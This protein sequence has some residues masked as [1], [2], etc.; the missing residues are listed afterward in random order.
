MDTL[1]STDYYKA[2]KTSNPAN[3]PGADFPMGKSA[4]TIPDGPEPPKQELY[5]WMRENTNRDM[6]IFTGDSTE[7]SGTGMSGPSRLTLPGIR[8][9]RGVFPIASA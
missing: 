3:L 4:S 1:N 9:R 8:V 5:A 6:L 2:S 7:S